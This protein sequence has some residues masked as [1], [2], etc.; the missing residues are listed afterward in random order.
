MKTINYRVCLDHPVKT[1]N[2]KLLKLKLCKLI[3]LLMA[4]MTT[5]ID[6][7]T[8]YRITED[9]IM[10]AIVEFPR[11]VKEALEECAAF[12]IERRQ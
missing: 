5:D 10:P 9:S 7:R 11:V 12:E 8:H 6:S 1:F 4:P 3:V 2:V